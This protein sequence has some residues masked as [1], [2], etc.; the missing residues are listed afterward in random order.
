MVERL[1]DAGLPDG[2]VNFF[3]GHPH[4]FYLFEHTELVFVF[5]EDQVAFAIGAFPQDFH[6]L[7]V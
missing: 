3:L 4:D 6:L 2:F 7:E 5:V 1:E